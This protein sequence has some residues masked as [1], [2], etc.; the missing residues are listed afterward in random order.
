MNT[1]IIPTSPLA[2]AAF[3]G[4]SLSGALALG[5]ILNLAQNTAAR[6][7]TDYVDYV[8][9]PGPTPTI[10]GKDAE[11]QLKR[12]ELKTARGVLRVAKAAA[13]EF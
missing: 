8:G 7:S 10:R 2:L 1:R 12:E 6:I 9:E 4:R 5:V 11:S 13:R 3:A